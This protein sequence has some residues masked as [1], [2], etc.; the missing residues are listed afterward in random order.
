MK[1]LI[2][3][4][5]SGLGRET[6]FVARDC[7]KIKKEWDIL[8]FI[9]GDKS[10]HGKMIDECPVLGDF[11]WLC[12]HIDTNIYGI[13]GI[14]NTKLREKI[15]KKGKKIGLNFVSLIHPS[16]KMSKYV[17]I[18]EGTV[19]TAQNIITTQV[20]I[21][22]HVFLNLNCT[23]GHDAILEDYVNCAPACNISGGVIL[24]KGAHLGTKVGV[25]Q[26]LTIGEWTRIGAGATV[27][28]N[29]P[30]NCTAVGTPAKVIKKRDLI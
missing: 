16:V 9:D 6:L 4:G 23:I 29:I 28:S 13:C 10:L 15:A 19:I 8:G 5:A 14:G 18:G 17:K 11:S 21:G 2:I 22:N 25:I 26:N 3:I 20:V 27:I 7:N 30:N 1:K 12:E 24:K